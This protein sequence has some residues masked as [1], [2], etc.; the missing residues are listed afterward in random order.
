MFWF[1]YDM[2]RTDRTYKLFFSTARGAISQETS[3]GERTGGL[4]HRQTCLN[5]RADDS[6]NVCR[7]SESISQDVLL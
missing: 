5:I 6:S 3:K 7:T 2:Q 1:E 4:H